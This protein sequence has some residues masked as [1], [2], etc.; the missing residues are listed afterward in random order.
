MLYSCVVCTQ[1]FV[2]LLLRSFAAC[3]HV[4]N[5]HDVYRG[6]L[7]LCVICVKVLHTGFECVLK[8]F[9]YRFCLHT[10]VCIQVS[11]ANWSY[12]HIEVASEH[13]LFLCVF[14]HRY[15]LCNIVF[16]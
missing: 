2:Y 7:R 9:V 16:F 15:C 12:W 4:L 3:V 14:A 8:L 1:V 13:T 10:G 5:T 6:C 11:F